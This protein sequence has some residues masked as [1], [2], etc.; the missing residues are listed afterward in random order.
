MLQVWLSAMSY[1]GSYEVWLVNA[2]LTKPSWPCNTTLVLV[3]LQLLL[4]INWGSQTSQGKPC[5][6]GSYHIDRLV[7]Q[8][9]LVQILFHIHKELK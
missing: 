6:K 4:C 7:H 3:E 2:K 9:N 5:E 1:V 8:F